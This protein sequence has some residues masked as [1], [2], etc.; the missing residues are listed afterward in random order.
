MWKTLSCVLILFLLATGHSVFSQ[1]HEKIS[2]A[3]EYYDGGDLDK[4][5]A[6]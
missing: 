2:L 5:Y 6:L 1:D 3:Q 4:A